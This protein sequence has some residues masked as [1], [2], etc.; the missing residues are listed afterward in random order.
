[1]EEA[2]EQCLCGGECVVVGWYCQEAA[3]FWVM[4]FQEWKVWVELGEK[5]VLLVWKVAVQ[6]EGEG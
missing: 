1:M 5:L 3:P 4:E 6:E 2:W